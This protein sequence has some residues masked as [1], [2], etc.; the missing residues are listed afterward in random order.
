VQ[1]EAE[2]RS[3]LASG[4][5]GACMVRAESATDAHVEL[6]AFGD[7]AP[8]RVG[9]PAEPHTGHRLEGARVAR[10]AHPAQE[11]GAGAHHPPHLSE[12]DGDHRGVGQAADPHRDVDAL[13][14]QI[15]HSIDQEELDSHVLVG[16]EEVE[17]QRRDVQLSEQHRRGHPELNQWIERAR[18]RRPADL[19]LLLERFEA[20]LERGHMF[21]IRAALE[22]L[23]GW[24]EDPRLGARALDWRKRLGAG[25]GAVRNV[26]LRLDK[27]L[28]S[29]ASHGALER[30]RALGPAGERLVKVLERKLSSAVP[31]APEQ[32]ALVERC[33][34]LA[35]HA[36]L[37]AEDG[38]AE[39]ARE[40]L[41]AAVYAAPHDDHRRLVF[42]DWLH[43]RGDPWGELIT[44]QYGEASGAAERRQKALIAKHGRRWLGGL[45]Q[46]VKNEGLGFTR[47]FPSR[48]RLRPIR[49]ARAAAELEHREWAT[50]EDIEFDLRMTTGVSV[51]SPKMRSARRLVNVCGAGIA[52]LATECAHLPVEEIVYG[53]Y[54]PLVELEPL[55]ACRGLEALRVLRIANPRLTR[56][57][58]LGWLKRSPLG[59][60]L[61][62]I[63]FGD[64]S[65][66]RGE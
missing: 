57:R 16:P 39:T 38:A 22:E 5:R 45:E 53:G 32:R 31:L 33:A 6:A 54:K 59:K 36:Q 42:A 66:G 63:L 20:I 47:G 7:E 23:V 17:R 29:G 8:R 43:E 27:L 14:D 30:A 28:V 65:G 56:L 48:V 13:F 40:E 61:D 10:D 44:L 12:G 64:P 26:E 35:A 1:E 60:R 11:R 19:E 2:P 15:D 4:E 49:R 18:R 52:A 21:Q 46:I 58:D 37:E 24:P 50:I 34:E 9:Q 62:A 51:I 25:G 3:G 55:A 41:L